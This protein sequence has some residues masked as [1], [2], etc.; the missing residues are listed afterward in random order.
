MTNRQSKKGIQ[1]V[2]ACIFCGLLFVLLLLFFG[3]PD[4]SFSETEKRVLADFPKMTLSSVADGSFEKG[5][6]DYVQDQMP[7]R[8]FWVGFGAYFDYAL[9]QNGTNGVYAAQDGYLMN[10]PTQQNNRNLYSNLKY[11]TAFAE[12]LQIPA[13]LMPV[14]ETGY[15]LEDK[16]PA[17]HKAYADDA[18]F[19]AVSEKTDGVYTV[20]DVRALFKANAA[21]TQLYYKT[22]HHW[23]SHGAF[24]AANAFLSAAEKTALSESDFS[25]ERCPGFYGTTYSKAALWKKMPDVME[26][27][28]IP[29]AA[30]HTVV[31]DLGKGIV[32]EADDVFF[33]EHLQAYDMYPTYL[34]G[35]H[36]LTHIV[37]PQAPEGVLLLLKDS[38]GN[39]L[40]T[41]LAAAYR[42][43]VMV[44]MRYYRTKAVSELAAQYGA[45]TLLVNYGTD[46]LIHDTNIL[47]L[48]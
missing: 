17:R 11:L 36:S 25:V 1:T 31:S 34:N 8:N 42:E 28:H 44:D 46:S 19:A 47:F 23:T 21:Q 26:L 4:K 45:D 43:I 9:G 18:V 24:L 6:E 40:A 29:D 5:L 38:F 15:V 13:Y 30:I 10:T 22:D 41:E 7:L 20:V 48:K 3:I 32:A 2:T 12:K 35:N 27:W 33:T 39:T 37:N 14:P 16:L